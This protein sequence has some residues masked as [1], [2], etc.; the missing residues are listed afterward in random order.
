MADLLLCNSANEIVLDD[1]TR[2]YLI[3]ATFMHELGH[4]LGLRHGGCDDINNKPNYFSIM[5]Y[6]FPIGIP[7]PTAT[8]PFRVDYSDSAVVHDDWNN[9]VFNWGVEGSSQIAMDIEMPGWSAIGDMPDEITIEEAL[10][11]AVEAQELA[12]KQHLGTLSITNAPTK[13]LQYKSSV[14]LTASEP[15]TWSSNSSAVKVNPATG[16]VESIS[17][18]GFTKSGTTVITATSLDGQRTASVTIQIK[19]VWWQWIIIIVLFGWLWF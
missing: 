16:K 17:V 8:P 18:F 19:P 13:P 3:A 15:V 14:T 9:L 5:N 4:T 10:A 12:K 2:D 1:T 7:A 6:M 11:S